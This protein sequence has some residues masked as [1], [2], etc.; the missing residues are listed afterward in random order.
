M[1]PN[2]KNKY[3]LAVRM[4]EDGAIEAFDDVSLNYE[5]C[6]KNVLR[7]ISGND[8]IDVKGVAL[9]SNLDWRSRLILV[10]CVQ[11]LIMEIGL[12]CT[13]DVS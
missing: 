8:V 10:V 5:T 12:Q 3:R 2:I 11:K 4:V 9:S 13:Y 7:I 6:Q 1:D